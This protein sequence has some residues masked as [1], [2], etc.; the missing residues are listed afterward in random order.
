VVAAVPDVLDNRGLTGAT[1]LCG[2]VEQP[3]VVVGVVTM[4]CGHSDGVAQ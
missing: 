1:S 2:V 4:V 3:S